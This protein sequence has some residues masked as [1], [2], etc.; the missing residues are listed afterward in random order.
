MTRILKVG[1]VA[2]LV[3][4]PIAVWAG[5][6]QRGAHVFQTYCSMCHDNVRDGPPNFGPNLFGVLGRKAGSLPG[7][8]YSAAVRAA[9]FA[10]SA[11][12]LKAFVE[13]PA[14]VIPG[15]K[16]PF[17]GM[18]DPDDREDLVAY[19]ATLK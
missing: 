11:D 2:L 3:A 9:A 15:V 6:G 18:P 16:M 8:D 5:D 10:W 14:N 4:K 1:L 17:R 13:L 12:R 7:F 19:L